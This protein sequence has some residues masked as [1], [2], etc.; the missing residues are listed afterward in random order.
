MRLYVALRPVWGLW[1][2]TRRPGGAGG[3]SSV[4]DRKPLVDIYYETFKT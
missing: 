3:G 2:A 4:A 1:G